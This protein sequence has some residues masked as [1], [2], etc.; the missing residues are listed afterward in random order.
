MRFFRNDVLKQISVGI[1]LLLLVWAAP[2]AAKIIQCSTPSSVCPQRIC[3]EYD[4]DVM[5]VGETQRIALTGG[6]PPYGHSFD[7]GWQVIDLKPDTGNGFLVTALRKSWGTGGAGMPQFFFLDNRRCASGRV[8]FQ[9][10]EARQPA[11]SAPGASSPAAGHSETQPPVSPTTRQAGAAAMLFSDEFRGTVL[12]TAK[13]EVWV[14]TGKGTG[15]SQGTGHSVTIR[16]GSLILGQDKADAGGAV[17]SKQIVPVPGKMLRIVKRTLVRHANQYFAGST[18]ILGANPSSELLAQVGYFHYFASG[19]SVNG[20]TAGYID[21]PSRIAPI[22]NQWFEEV[23]TYNP[24]TG[25]M[26]VSVNGGTPVSFS[27]KPTAHPFR[28]GMHAYGWGTGHSHMVNGIRLE[29]IDAGNGTVSAALPAAPHDLNGVW[30]EQTGLPNAV[31]VIFHEGNDVRV[32][33][34]YEYQGKKIVWHGAGKK[35]GNRVTLTYHYTAN[36][37]PPGWE[38]GTIELTVSADGSALSGT[39]RTAGS[40]RSSAMQFKR[41]SIRHE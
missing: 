41:T 40:G 10:V 16:D 13:W 23:I 21:S 33:S 11:A 38:D 31:A 18:G 35:N 3:A 20:F 1:A 22:W 17:V 30:T 32:M 8:E 25:R 34:T 29:W 27:G 12:D 24:A 7:Q 4:K 2:A 15:F 19:R 5:N 26:T 14:S 6:I 9:V 36:T 37:R 39:A 28:I